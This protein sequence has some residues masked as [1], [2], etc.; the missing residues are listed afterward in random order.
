[1]KRLFK[2]HCT[3][4]KVKRETRDCTYLLINTVATIT[5]TKI[6]IAVTT[7]PVMGTASMRCFE[8][9]TG[10]RKSIFYYP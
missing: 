3:F 4:I 5:A 2:C 10:T 6:I 1:M 8:E 9:S 7:P